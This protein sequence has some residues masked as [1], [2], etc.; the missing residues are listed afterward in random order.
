MKLMANCALGNAA[1]TEIYDW[2]M[3]T[4]A[5]DLFARRNDFD[6]FVAGLGP[7]IF[8]SEYAVM[9]GAGWG[10][11]KVRHSARGCTAVHLMPGLQ[12]QSMPY[13]EY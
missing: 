2:H 6:Q 10:N 3:Y 7:Q 9:V 5:D 1:P 12:M 11:M 13:S 8:A 4:S